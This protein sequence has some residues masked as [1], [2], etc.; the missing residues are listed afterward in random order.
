MARRYKKDLVFIDR[1]E[2]IKRLITSGLIKSSDKRRRSAA[3]IILQRIKKG[4]HCSI[5]NYSLDIYFNG[6]LMASF[7]TEY[8]FI[9]KGGMNLRRI[10]FTSSNRIRVSIIY[11][12]CTFKDYL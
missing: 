1:P 7:T 9:S 2:S 12:F 10:D 11:S 5:L 4:S 3:I 6:L 8:S